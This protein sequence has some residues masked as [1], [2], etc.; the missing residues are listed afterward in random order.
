MSAA[1]SGDAFAAT[2]I[3]AA[4][5]PFCFSASMPRSA[6][7]MSWNTPTVNNADSTWAIPLSGFCFAKGTLLTVSLIRGGFKGEA[8]PTPCRTTTRM[9]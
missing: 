2:D 8:A 7:A 3:D 9:C 6:H 4:V 5:N 1:A